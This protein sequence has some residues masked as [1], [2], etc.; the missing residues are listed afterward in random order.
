M[1]LVGLWLMA[2]KNQAEFISLLHIT[3]QDKASQRNRKKNRTFSLDFDALKFVW[4]LMIGG[5]N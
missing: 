2:Y 5:R 3:M 4:C 1:Y